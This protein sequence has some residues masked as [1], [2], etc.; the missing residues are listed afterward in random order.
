M[1]TLIKTIVVMLIAVLSL[2]GSTGNYSWERAA[3]ALEASDKEMGDYFGV[4]ISRSLNYAVVGAPDTSMGGSAYVFKK[5]P[6]GE[7]TQMQKLSNPNMPTDSYIGSFG[8]SVGIAEPSGVLNSNPTVLIIGAPGS[9]KYDNGVNQITGAVCVYKLDMTWNQQGKCIMGVSNSPEGSAFGYSVAISNWTLATQ[10][11]PGMR[12]I[13]PQLDIVVGDPGWDMKYV[14]NG[15][16]VFY[17]YNTTSNSLELVNLIVDHEGAGGGSDDV[18][19]GKSVALYDGT[20]IISAPGLKRADPND[21]PDDNV[22]DTIDKMGRVYFFT[23]NGAFISGYTPPH[24]ETSGGHQFGYSVDIF[25]KYAIVGEKHKE[26]GLS[27][28]AAYILKNDGDWTPIAMKTSSADGYGYS[29]AINDTHAAVGAPY[30]GTS[31][32]TIVTYANN[33][34]TWGET[35]TFSFEKMSAFGISVEL[36][37]DTLMVGA[38][39]QERVERFEFVRKTPVFNPSLIMYLLN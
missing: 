16:A 27:D 5:E 11:Q 21:D 32:G 36:H 13:T 22:V 17:D 15:L 35:E 31:N 30:K 29:V 19:L 38:P 6:N 23:S 3:H 7:W 26:G 14:N 28:G 2:F 12:R 10:T 33:A 25:G 4:S 37:N 39:L 1:K 18:E 8:Y 20:A 34:D 24:E 9:E